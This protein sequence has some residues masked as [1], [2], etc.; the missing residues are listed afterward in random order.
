M[1]GF[2]GS[3]PAGAVC[4]G[5]TVLKGRQAPHAAA[6]SKELLR[7]LAA[8]Q[9]GSEAEV[10]V[11]FFVRHAQQGCTPGRAPQLGNLWHPTANIRSVGGLP[12]SGEWARTAQYTSQPP[13][14]AT[15]DQF[16]RRASAD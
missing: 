6:R 4:S 2:W 15:S 11:D 14:V 16:T 1:R 5:M 12:H 7:A 10:L 13:S 8:S 9:Q 3:V